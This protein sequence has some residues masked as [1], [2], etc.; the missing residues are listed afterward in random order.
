MENSIKN[1][2]MMVAAYWKDRYNDEISNT[3]D[4]D[5]L[6]E[7]NQG[8]DETLVLL[9]MS[10]EKIFGLQYHG[11]EHTMGFYSFF[12]ELDNMQ[13]RLSIVKNLINK[14]GS[15]INLEDYPIA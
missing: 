1:N 10:R 7:L 11:R 13:E 2:L 14:S 9:K 12:Q 5:K 15:R 8:I 4:P 3:I 6:R